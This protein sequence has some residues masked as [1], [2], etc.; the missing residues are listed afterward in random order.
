LSINA[1][2]FNGVTT[3][4]VTL[5]VPAGTGA[6]YR[7]DP[8]WGGFNIE[9]ISVTGVSLNK[10]A[11]SLTVDATE[12]LIATVLPANADNK[13]V[14]WISSNES[15]ATVA[16]GLVTA[17]AEGEATITVT[18]EDGEFT[19]T[20]AVTVT[21]N[22][23]S[24][25][26]VSLNKTALSLTVNA[27]EQLTA[28]VLPANADN[29]AV[30][31][32]SSNAS[33]ATV[34]NGLV[35]AISE[36]AATIT[37]TTEDGEFTAT[38]AVT[39]TRNIV[40]V[41][42]IS[43][44][45]TKLTLQKPF[46][47]T[48]LKHQ[49]TATVFPENADNKNVIWTSNNPT[50]VSVSQTGLLTTQPNRTGRAIITAITEDGAFS[51]TCMVTVTDFREE[52]NWND[53]I[54]MLSIFS[55]LLTLQNDV[56]NGYIIITLPAGLSLSPN[57]T[58]VNEAD[59]TLG[60]I[61]QISAS[62]WRIGLAS[63]TLRSATENGEPELLIEIGYTASEST[64]DGDYEAIIDTLELTFDD[65]TIVKEEEVPVT[66]NV[67]RAG[68]AI[69]NV[70]KAQLMVSV[71]NNVLKIGGLSAGDLFNV[72][73]MQGVL[74]YKGKATA[75]EAYVNLPS[76]AIYIVTAGKERVKVR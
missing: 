6:L 61:T 3:S 41:T 56:N 40:A 30:T 48:Q 27:T 15:V 52:T 63:R 11:L 18:T 22:I 62:Q 1:D 36:G 28:T 39:V 38:C 7:A 37:V 43:L 67:N 54:G 66:V 35:T 32:T 46:T 2:V 53:N 72:Y 74:I 9:L 29:K 13:A 42:G 12:Q 34:A 20:C 68:T 8:V 4:E 58:R 23:V 60:E 69:A 17:I 45:I 26:G 57:A 51:A 65:G 25:T 76:R 14:T 73:N 31:W 44:D 19:A 64:A 49:L 75:S 33:V 59:L 5:H 50:V 70:V 21:R 16:N 47:D 10:T 55:T 71:R 24:V